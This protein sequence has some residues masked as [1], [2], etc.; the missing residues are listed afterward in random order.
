[1]SI[2]VCST[3]KESKFLSL[4]HDDKNKKDGKLSRCKSCESV[5]KKL[6]YNSN[7]DVIKEK[8]LSYHHD[9][10]ERVLSRKQSY[11]HKNKNDINAKRRLFKEMWSAQSSKRRA[12]KLKATPPWLSKEH[13]KEIQNLFWLARDLRSVTGEEYHVDHIVPL[14]NKIVCGL[15]VPWNLQILPSDINLSKSNSFDDQ[16]E[17]LNYAH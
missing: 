3:C 14:T 9:N 10:R 2:K 5:R 1:M 11:W 8:A 12:N 17:G 15:H 7:S 13:Q 4:F 6:Y 16:E